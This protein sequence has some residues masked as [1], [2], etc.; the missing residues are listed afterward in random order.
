MF[1]RKIKGLPTSNCHNSLVG[2]EWESASALCAGAGSWSYVLS[3]YQFQSPSIIDE[4]RVIKTPEGGLRAYLH[5]APHANPG[6][7][8]DIKRKFS[9]LRWTEIPHVFEG[10]PVLEVRGFKKP[11]QLLSYLQSNGWTAGAAAVTATKDDV[12]RFSDQLRALTLKA[13]G[14]TYVISDMGYYAYAL[15]NYLHEPSAAHRFDLAAGVGYNLGS[16]VLLGYGSQDQSQR[17]IK[18]A[19]KKMYRYL[20]QQMANL[21]E[22][23]EIHDVVREEKRGVIGNINEFLSRYPSEITN[24]VFMLTGLAIL[25]ANYTNAFKPQAADETLKQFRD[26][27]NSRIM[28]MGLGSITALSGLGAITIP[29]KKRAEGDP[30][31]PGLLGVWDW[32]QEKPLRLAGYGYMVATAFHAVS[33][34]NEW[35]SGNQRVR[36]TLAWR[37]LFVAGNVIAETLMAVS[38]KG[39]GQGVHAEGGVDDS[40]IATAADSIA[41]QKPEY[42]SLLVSQ[43][44][45]FLSSP[46]VLGGK[47]EAIETKLREQLAMMQHHPWRKEATPAKEGSW[48]QRTQPATVPNT[49]LSPA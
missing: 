11:E 8:D 34:Y 26:R 1:F 14:A 32:V 47:A 27:R 22:H 39:H 20:R 24:A 2:L 28:D 12:I 45:G 16:W 30:Y 37:V 44:A 17:Q 46:E 19:T 23:A 42:Q 25:R 7:L 4:V 40:V 5:A 21:P 36:E 15:K 43:L 18:D 38:S 10:K 13:S 6:Q 35:R 3:L 48:Q 41:R 33:T 49:A 29:E 9:V 31:R